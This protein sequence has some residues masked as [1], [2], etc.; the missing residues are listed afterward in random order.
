MREAFP[1]K[2]KGMHWRTYDRLRRVHDVGGCCTSRDGG[3]DD[4]GEREDYGAVVRTTP[5]GAPTAARAP[6]AR[7]YRLSGALGLPVLRPG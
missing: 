7:A 2:T 4:A 6:A 5:A 3:A 1:D